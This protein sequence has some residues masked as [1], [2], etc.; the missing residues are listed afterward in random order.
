[1]LACPLIEA[2]VIGVQSLLFFEVHLRP[3]FKEEPWL[4][5]HV[6]RPTLCL[7]VSDLHRFSSYIGSCLKEGPEISVCPCSEVVSNGVQPGLSVVP[8]SAPYQ[9]KPNNIGVIIERCYVQCRSAIRSFHVDI[10][11]LAREEPDKRGV[12][13][14]QG[15]C[16]WR[17]TLIDSVNASFTFF[18]KKPL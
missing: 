3:L 2:A 1:M 9:E 15:N 4:L 13:M 16:Q 14:G 7:T 12:S 8:M 17:P 11:C 5:R 10:K 18:F 6:H